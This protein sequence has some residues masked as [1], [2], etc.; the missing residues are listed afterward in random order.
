MRPS[1]AKNPFLTAAQEK[2]PY[3]LEQ[4]GGSIGGRILK[5]KLFY[6][7][8]FEGQRVGVGIPA[9]VSEPTTATSATSANGFPAAIAALNAQGLN[10]RISPLSLNLA[11]CTPSASTVA[12]NISCNAAAGVFGNAGAATSY[13]TDLLDS[14]SSNNY[15]GR[16]DYHLND[17]NAINGEYFNGRGNY[18]FPSGKVQ[19][20]WRNLNYADAQFVRGVWVWT[21]SS[22]W[23]NEARFGFNYS[24]IPSY[25]AECNENVGQPN[26]LAAYGFVSGAP[27]QPGSGI[28]GFPS[29]SIGTFTTLG[30]ASQPLTVKWSTFEGSDNVSYTHGKHLFKFGAELGHTNFFGSTYVN[31][32]GA[33]GFGTGGINAPGIASPTAL[34]DFLVGY[35]STG[36][37]LVGNATRT[38]LWLQSGV[39]SGEDCT[40]K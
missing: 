6:I 13:T 33:I 16:I 34:E 26:Y 27:P 15:I 25:V 35:N 8:S 10:N 32:M 20:Y 4:F 38:L 18:L 9:G 39:F 28:C 31:A 7:G 29:A 1:N 24:L 37:L 23:V 30:G 36:S 14:G 5:D 19:S 2:A 40:G 22:T 17:H 12:A 3:E 21:P 11:G